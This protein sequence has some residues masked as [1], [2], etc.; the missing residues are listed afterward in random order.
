MAMESGHNRAARMLTRRGLL[1]KMLVVGAGSGLACTLGL[2]M[3][4][5]CAG[6]DK[7]MAAPPRPRMRPTPTLP[8]RSHEARFYSHLDDGS[9][10]CG[11]CWRRC[12]VSPGRL[13]FCLNKKNVDGTYYSLVYDRPA[14]LQV[15]AIEKEPAFHMLPGA[16]IFCTGTASCNNRCKFCQNWELSQYPRGQVHNLDR[17]VDEIVALAQEAGC[18]AVSFT[19]NEPTVFYEFMYDIA[20]RAKEAG[21]WALFHTNGSMNREPM[22]ALLE[23]MDAVTVDLKAF[24]EE[25]YHRVSS[26]SLEPVLRTL[27]TV[28]G[29]GKHLEI[30]NLIIPT[31]NDD[32]DDIRRMCAWIKASLGDDVPLHFI[33]F[34]P[35]YKLQ[36]LPPT[37]VE[38]LEAAAAAADAEGLQYVYIGN[39]PGHQ[40][41]SSFCPCCGETLISRVHFAMLDLKLDHGRCPACGHKIPGIWWD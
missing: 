25:F 35:A 3:L 31:L 36:R 21:L 8:P 2:E 17:S 10:Q 40:R 7:P 16:T 30:V 28:R 14:A 34:F 37:P 5:G 11:V 27:E 32:P 15:D 18:D 6:E 29:A 41:N 9:I 38:T 1:K 12:V 33:R 23:V 26:S 24:T 13:G 22:L 4:S 19:Y 39:V 20:A